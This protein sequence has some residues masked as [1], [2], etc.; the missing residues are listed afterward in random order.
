MRITTRSLGIVAALAAGTMLAS[1]CAPTTPT[2]EGVGQGTP[3][4]SV[5]VPVNPQPTPTEWAVD[6]TTPGL[7]DNLPD[8]VIDTPDGAP[9]IP[10]VVE[11]GNLDGLTFAPAGDFSATQTRS[12]FDFASAFAAYRYS[13]G[14]WSDGDK[15][16]LVPVVY[17]VYSEFLSKEAKENY[18]E[19]VAD[20]A[21]VAK[22]QESLDAMAPPAPPIGEGRWMSPA[23][24]NWTFGQPTFTSNGKALS[25]AFEMAGVAIWVSSDG[26]YWGAVVRD[27]VALTLSDDK[28]WHVDDWASTRSI[29]EPFMLD[30]AP[31][32]RYLPERVITDVTEL[33]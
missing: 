21:S 2:V 29:E 22:N 31:I 11:Q 5:T 25:V 7:P 16:A 13:S 26:V 33:S 24:A 3:T 20:A 17:Y 15:E 28:G 19:M 1:A 32:G 14:L 4:P 30:Q 9:E 10:V 6:D 12:A 23:V 8:E 18:Y 27:K